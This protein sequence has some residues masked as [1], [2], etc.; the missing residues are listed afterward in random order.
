MFACCVFCVL[1]GISL[2]DELNT[3]PEEAY[4]LRRV[5]VCDQ[6]TWAAEPEKINK[7]LRLIPVVYLDPLNMRNIKKRKILQKHARP[8]PEDHCIPFP[9]FFP[10]S[11]S[12]VE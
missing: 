12:I 6:E 3:R 9:Y 8:S 11:P 5:V 1:S 4:R 2:C 10:T 7:Y